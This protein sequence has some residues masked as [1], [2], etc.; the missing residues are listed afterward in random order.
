[1]LATVEAHVMPWGKPGSPVP[2]AII[3]PVSG[4][5]ALESRCPVVKTRVE[6]QAVQ[7]VGSGPDDPAEGEGVTQPWR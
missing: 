5:D 7:Q 3:H 2:H 4:T 1:M 6:V